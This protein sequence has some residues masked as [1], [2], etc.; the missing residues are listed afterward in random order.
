MAKRILERIQKGDGP[1]LPMNSQASS[2]AEV[3]PVYMFEAQ[4]GQGRVEADI[5]A[6]PN[7]ESP[8]TGSL[9]YRVARTRTFPGRPNQ[10]EIS[11]T[12]FSLGR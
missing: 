3:M 5:E 2:A 11:L 12:V 8:A 4:W 10:P 1:L 7:S 6:I 9:R